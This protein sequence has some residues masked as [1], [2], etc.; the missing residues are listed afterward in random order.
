MTSSVAMSIQPMGTWPLLI[1][2]L[3]FVYMTLTDLE[4]QRVV[5]KAQQG[6]NR[7]WS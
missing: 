4:E 5:R 3:I 2:H 1:S 7:V 6:L